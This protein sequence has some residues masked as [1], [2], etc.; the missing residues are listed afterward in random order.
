LL[1]E[2]I[3]KILLGKID[4]GLE[5]LGIFEI[6]S[7]VLSKLRISL[8]SFSEL[9]TFNARDIYHS[10]GSLDGLFT[11]LDLQGKKLAVLYLGLGIIAFGVVHY[12]LV[13]GKSLWL[14][15]LIYLPYLLGW[16]AYVYMSSFYY[17]SICFD[18][19]RWSSIS[20]LL[21]VVINSFLLFVTMRIFGPE[22][23]APIICLSMLLSCASGYFLMNRELRLDL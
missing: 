10:A 5:L 14:L 2:P 23:F 22:I 7:Q 18:S 21:L 3:S 12:L 4:G 19:L 16:T 20:N 8:C 17:A 11:Y 13:P 1:F 6:S 15:T 9:N